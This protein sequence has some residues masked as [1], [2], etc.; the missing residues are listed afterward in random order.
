MAAAGAA[1]AVLALAGAAGLKLLRAR[2]K[3]Q[4]LPSDVLLVVDIGSSSVRCSVLHVHRMQQLV[5]GAT[6]RVRDVVLFVLSLYIARVV[7]AGVL[8]P[9]VLAEPSPG[10]EGHGSARPGGRGGDPRLRRRVH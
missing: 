7:C 9:F 3:L 10:E 8:S 2:R 1:F 5:P 6:F 4:R